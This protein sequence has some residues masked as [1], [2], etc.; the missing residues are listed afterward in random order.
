[1][2]RNTKLSQLVDDLSVL[3]NDLSELVEPEEYPVQVEILSTEPRLAGKMFTYNDTYAGLHVDDLVLVPVNTAT[4]VGIVRA[5][6]R[7]MYTG[8]LRN[9]TSLLEE[10]PLDTA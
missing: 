10:R 3:I 2:D 5:R 8:P 1:M 9:V 6:G 4:K 7:N